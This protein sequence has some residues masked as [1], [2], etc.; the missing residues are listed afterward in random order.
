MATFTGDLSEV[1]TRNEVDESQ[2]LEFEKIQCAS[3][4][5]AQNYRL[6]GDGT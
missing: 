1:K 4:E 5:K 2:L 3:G 6:Q